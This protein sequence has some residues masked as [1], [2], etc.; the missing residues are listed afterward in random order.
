L[1]N[2]D[3]KL[4]V[5]D[6]DRTLLHTDKTL[7]A[8]TVEVLNRCREKG[9]KLAFATARPFC[10]GSQYGILP[11][12]ERLA[13]LPDALITSNGAEV[14]IGR[15]RHKH[16]PIAPGLRDTTLRLLK[17]A[18]PEGFIFVEIGEEIYGNVPGAVHGD[19]TKLPDEAANMIFIG[20]D[21]TAEVHALA[22]LLHEDLYIE[23]S[24]GEEHHLGLILHKTAGKWTGVK[25]AARFFNILVENI[26]VF[27]DD[28]IDLEMIKNAGVG[29]A[30]ENAAPEVKKVARFVCG[31][32]NEDGVARW[33][34]EHIVCR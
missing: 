16:F 12:A 30:V 19:F 28:F 31:S 34:E 2:M 9:V 33:L 26:A 7:S 21:S 14:Y 1:Q 22:P 29:V 15:R 3:I 13:A 23:M 10:N 8:Y 27:G 32:N 17:Q 20:V 4:V 6:L 24:H 25:E 18:K 5:T 11:F